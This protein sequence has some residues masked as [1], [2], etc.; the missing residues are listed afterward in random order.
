[1]VETLSLESVPLVILAGGRA[2]RLGN[3]ANHTPK[4]L[5]PIG[6]N[7]CFAD[8]HLAWVKRQ[9]FKKVILAIGY[10]GEKIQAHCGQGVR[11]GLD[12]SYVEDGRQPLG[13]GGALKL[14]LESIPDFAA[15]TYGDTALCLNAHEIFS[16]FRVT[17]FDV[18]MSYFRLTVPGHVANIAQGE[19]GQIRYAKTQPG[20][21]WPFIDYGFMFFRAAFLTSLPQGAFDLAQPLEL[22]STQGRVGGVEVAERFWEIGSAAALEDFRAE[23]KK[24]PRFF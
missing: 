20:A 22:A 18:F 14:S 12:I 24:N 19:R 5:M 4:Y 10:L 1:M 3:L 23:L 17:A 15:L 21:N 7:L 2:T 16:A 9:G 6:E 11:Y 13:T 8:W